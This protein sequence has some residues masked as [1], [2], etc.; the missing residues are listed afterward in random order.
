M[1]K[2]LT[3]LQTS[4]FVIIL[5][6]GFGQPLQAG[7]V[8]TQG[9]LTNISISEDIGFL[10]QNIQQQLIELGVGVDQA[11][12]RVAGMSDTQILEISSRLKE[13]PAGADAG[14]TLLTIFIVFVI[15][16]V[17]GA[18]DIFPFIHPVK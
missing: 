2:L 5:F 4:I 1:L 14:G 12:L 11:N 6:L 13:L 17:I 8:G 3:P 7:M 15:T 9:L 18:T 16:D 10:R